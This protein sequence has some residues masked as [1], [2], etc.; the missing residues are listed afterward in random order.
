MAS[1]REFTMNYKNYDGFLKFCK[2][3][4]IGISMTILDLIIFNLLIRTDSFVSARA[5][6]LLI[7]L[8]LGFILSATYVFKITEKTIG[9]AGKWVVT[10]IISASIDVFVGFLLIIVFTSNFWTL[11]LAFVLGSLSAFVVNFYLCNRW[12]FRK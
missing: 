9:M 5:S 1:Y 7:T 12:V 4:L 10:H 11:N 2:F 3:I 8:T 6:S